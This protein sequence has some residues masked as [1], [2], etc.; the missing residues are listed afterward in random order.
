MVE[1]VEEQVPFVLF[2]SLK[3]SWKEMFALSLCLTTGLQVLCHSRCSKFFYVI[4]CQM[5]LGIVLERFL[6]VRVKTL[7]SIACWMDW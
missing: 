4:S 7:E 5:S 1:G 3:Y 2:E 6:R